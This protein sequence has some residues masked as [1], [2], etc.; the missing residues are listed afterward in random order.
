M[1]SSQRLRLLRLTASVGLA[2]ALFA[3]SSAPAQERPDLPTEA[4]AFLE[5]DQPQ[6]W[7]RWLEVG[8]QKFAEGSCSKCHGEGGQGGRFGPDLTDSEWVQSK[9]D[10]QGIRDTIFWGV[11]RK[12]FSSPDLRFEMN[13][14]GGMELEWG[15]IDAL[16]AFVWTLGR[17]ETAED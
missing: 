13:P 4:Q 14:Q 7:N 8:K 10:L 1:S 16:A 15:E 11:R 17:N 9:G 2:M 6:R 5:R 3:T 12:D